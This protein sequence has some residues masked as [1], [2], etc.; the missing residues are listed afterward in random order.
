M[1]CFAGIF[2]ELNQEQEQIAKEK[3]DLLEKIKKELKLIEGPQTLLTHTKVQNE[4]SE[5]DLESNQDE[6]QIFDDATLESTQMVLP[7]STAAWFDIE[8]IAEIEKDSLPEFFSG[9]Y[10]SKSPASYLE[11]R[12]FM[13]RLYR[14]NPTLYLTATACRRH[15]S[16]DAC[17]IIRVHSFLEKWGLINFLA[18]PESRPKRTGLLV[19]STYNKVLVNAANKHALVKNEQEYLG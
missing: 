16:G 7:S 4:D 14:M 1:A 2:L 13:I 19:E 18:D 11:Y 8:K 6:A 15:L 17:A 12:N 10:P 9:V 5:N 3:S